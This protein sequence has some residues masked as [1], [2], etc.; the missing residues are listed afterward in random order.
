MFD[1]AHTIIYVWFRGTQYTMRTMGFKYIRHNAINMVFVLP[2]LSKET[3]SVVL[4]TK[5]MVTI[6][7]F[8]AR[9]GFLFHTDMYASKC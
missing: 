1:L 5:G 4:E 6:R 9:F 8:P 3:R 7:E 2:I